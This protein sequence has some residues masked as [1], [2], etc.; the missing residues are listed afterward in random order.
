MCGWTLKGLTLL[1]APVALLG[2]ARGATVQVG[3][4]TVSPGASIAFSVTLHTMGALVAGT[5]NDLTFDSVAIPIVERSDG[6]PDC[7]VNRRIGKEKTSFAFRGPGGCAGAGCGGIRALVLSE[8][9]VGPHTGRVGSVYLS[10]SGGS[11]SF[12][13]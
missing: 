7:S 5:Q 3:T 4:V 2:V 12:R 8:L 11:G 9:N 10:P 6:K 13:G 1:L